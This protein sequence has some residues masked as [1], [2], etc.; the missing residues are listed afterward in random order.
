MPRDHLW[1]SGDRFKFQTA[2]AAPSLLAPS[3]RHKQRKKAAKKEG[4]KKE[5]DKKAEKRPC[6]LPDI[7]RREDVE[8]HPGLILS[9]ALDDHHDGQA[10][11][12]V[13]QQHDFSPHEDAGLPNLIATATDTIGDNHDLAA[14]NKGF[15]P[16]VAHELPIFSVLDYSAG[17]VGKAALYQFIY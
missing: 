6:S 11:E 13:V 14:A 9:G 2:R 12:I 17:R 1:T 3:P 8:Q 15:D 5:D 16:H 4:D 7:W 10:T